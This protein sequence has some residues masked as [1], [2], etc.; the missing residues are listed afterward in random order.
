V[1]VVARRLEQ[2]DAGHPGHALVG[3]H[4]RERLAAPAQLAHQVGRLDARARP[5]HAVL[6][7]EAAAQVALHG[8][9][10]R[11]LVVHHEQ[12][13]AADGRVGCGHAADASDRRGQTL[14]VDGGWSWGT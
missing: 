8:P 9:Q 4:E 14:Y 3:E 13:R 7:P 6:L 5:Q 12:G 1:N 11:R 2:L 10:H